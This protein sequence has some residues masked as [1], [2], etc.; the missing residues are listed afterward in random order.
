MKGIKKY[1]FK[2]L[3][4]F[5]SILMVIYLVPTF[6]FA[7]WIDELTPDTTGDNTDYTGHISETY[8]L[9]ELRE[10][11]VK[12]F[13]QPDGTN[14]AVVYEY[15]VHVLDD[16]DIWQEIDNTLSSEGSEISTPNARIKFAKKITGNESLFT[17]HDGSSKLVMSL[18]GAIKKTSGVI[19]NTDDRNTYSSD[20]QKLMTLEKLTSKII[21]RDIL[22]GV[23]LEYVIV[24][25][26]VKENIIVKKPLSCYT[27]T[28]TVSLNNLSAVLLDDGSVSIFDPQSGEQAYFIPHGYMYDAAGA[29]SDAVTYSLSDLGSGKYSFTVTADASWINSAVRSFPVTIDPTVNTAA[30]NYLDVYI[31]TETSGNSAVDSTILRAGDCYRT[32]LK[33]LSLPELPEY[34]YLTNAE[35][36]LRCNS[37]MAMDGYIAVYK[38]TSD[39]TAS[40]TSGSA[41]GALYSDAADFQYIYTVRKWIR[42][43]RG[44]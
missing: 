21:Y 11:N 42:S 38:V 20:L 17:L 29:Y 15:P 43:T 40:L 8:E 26:N 22:D 4:I 25:S 7:E 34:A 30:T 23:D 12:H 36:K 44:I 33:L 13:R 18:D 32:Y 14:V 5:L 19:E 27:Y 9:T 37:C 6:V 39:W 35:I 41:A 16:E 24:S 31:N 2:T 1:T 10:E 28:F 3:A